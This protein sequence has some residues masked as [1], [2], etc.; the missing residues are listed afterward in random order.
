[1][2]VDLVEPFV[3]PEAP[4]SY[5]D[6]NKEQIELSAPDNKTMMEKMGSQ[7]DT[8]INKDRREAMREQAKALLEG[9]ETW[10]KG[11]A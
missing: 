10:K 6:W 1:M 8:Y 3:W 7:R 4:E 2:T 5:T 9:R 11:G